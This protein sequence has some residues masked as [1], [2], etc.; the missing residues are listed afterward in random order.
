[1][2]GRLMVERNGTIN[3]FCVWEGGGGGE[4]PQDNVLWN[5]CYNNIA[6]NQMFSEFTRCHRILFDIH[7]CAVN[8]QD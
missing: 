6:G 7:C 1:M 2:Y 4:F 3:W 8:F 5:E